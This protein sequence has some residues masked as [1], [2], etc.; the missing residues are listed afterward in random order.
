[1]LHPLHELPRYCSTSWVAHL[2]FG[3][4]L[5][6]KTTIKYLG[7]RSVKHRHRRCDRDKHLG[8]S[9]TVKHRDQR[10]CPN[11]LAEIKFV[12]THNLLYNNSN[13]IY[14]YKVKLMLGR[15]ISMRAQKV[16]ATS[17][18]SQGQIMYSLVQI[19]RYIRKKG[20]E[21]YQAYAEKVKFYARV[22]GQSYT[23]LISRS[24][25]NHI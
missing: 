16:K 6:P 21:V 25:Y 18:S 10:D 3:G 5:I 14:A 24:F 22:K 20:Q 4:T 23:K 9:V 7:N 13:A 17:K 1:M 8:R 11:K 15:L 12:K 19:K 2:P